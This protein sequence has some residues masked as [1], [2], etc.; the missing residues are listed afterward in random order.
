M[1]VL[2][3][4]GRDYNDIHTMSAELSKLLKAKSITDPKDLI[5]VSGMAKG[6]DKLAHTLGTHNGIHVEEFPADW[7]NMSDPCVIKEGKYGA[8]NA[9][10]GHNRNKLMGDY[11]DI[12]LIFWNGRST[13]TK[14]MIDY[15]ESLHKET[16]VVNY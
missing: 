11:C 13:G 7:K 14:N 10:A 9:L 2:I 4:G 5:I 8:Y 6:A 12:A 1:K 16:I 3:A 15:M